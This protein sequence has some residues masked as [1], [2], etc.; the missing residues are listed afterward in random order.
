MLGY[1]KPYIPELLVR[2]HTRYRSI[3]CGVCKSLETFHGQF[4]RLGLSYD[5][6]FLVLFLLSFEE[7]LDDTEEQSCLNHL[8]KKLPVLKVRPLTEFAAGLTCYF[9]LAK[10]EDDL[11][12]GQALKAGLSKLFFRAGAEKFKKAYPELCGEV[13]QGL[14]DFWEYEQ[15]NFPVVGQNNLQNAQRI[16]EASAAYSGKMLVAVFS[17]AAGLLESK[18]FKDTRYFHLLKIFAQSLGEWVYLIDA[19]DDK[20]KDEEK[21][22]FNPY[23][24]LQA[25]EYIPLAVELLASRQNALDYRGALFPYYKDAGIIENILHLALPKQ[26]EQVIKNKGSLS[27]QYLLRYQNISEEA[28]EKSVL[29]AEKKVERNDEEE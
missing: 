27:E 8:G 17:E 21:G 13:Q 6:T 24:G 2:E 11:R 3:Y 19:L 25:E 1:L 14:E 23:L 29:E 26:R 5:I 28:R 10:A 9:A 18:I 7:E 22:L 20:E 4:E 15:T 12:D 16:A